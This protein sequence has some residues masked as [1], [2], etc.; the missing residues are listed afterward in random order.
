MKTLMLIGVLALAACAKNSG[1]CQNCGV[2][3]HPNG[4][5]ASKVQGECHS[6]GLKAAPWGGMAPTYICTQFTP[7]CQ[8]Q[9]SPLEQGIDQP[10]EIASTCPSYP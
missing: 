2:Y 5:L 3:P 9:I 8:V 6:A 1:D 7:V 4:V 10:L